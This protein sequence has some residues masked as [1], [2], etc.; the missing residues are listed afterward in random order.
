MLVEQHRLHR[1]LELRPV[2]DHMVA[3]LNSNGGKS[4]SG[5]KTPR[6]K[7]FTLE[8]VMPAMLIPP[9]LRGVQF[10]REEAQ[11]IVAAF[12]H[13]RGA[14]W[15]LNALVNRVISAEKLEALANT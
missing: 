8:D 1:F 4:D 5:K 2:Y 13:L 15:V 3:H 6:S 11:A 10:T 9:E 7:L 14:G 12:P